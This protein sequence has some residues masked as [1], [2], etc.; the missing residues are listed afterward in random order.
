MN[1]AAMSFAI[2]STM[3]RR[4]FSSKRHSFYCIGFDPDLMLRLCLATLGGIPF[5]SEG[6][7]ANL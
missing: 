3:A 1:P 4:F 5:M 7:Q 6:F 2:S